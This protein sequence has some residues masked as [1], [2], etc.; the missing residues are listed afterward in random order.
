MAF[1]GHVGLICIMARTGEHM[2]DL[3]KHVHAKEKLGDGDMYKVCT[4]LV[5][6]QLDTVPSGRR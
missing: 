5:Q 4:T 2:M 6:D 1:M 3:T